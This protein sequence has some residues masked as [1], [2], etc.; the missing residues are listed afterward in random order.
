MK[1]SVQSNMDFSFLSEYMMVSHLLG[2]SPVV[3]GIVG[4]V[5]GTVGFV[6]SL[7]GSVVLCITNNL[8]K[9]TNQNYGKVLTWC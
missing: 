1:E 2:L 8:M 6:Y 3:T 4:S 5:F 7:I 9:Y